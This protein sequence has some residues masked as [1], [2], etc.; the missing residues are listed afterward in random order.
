VG[1]L[2]ARG[3]GRSA[4]L[5][6]L[7]M[8]VLLAL[9]GARWAGV[10][11]P[12]VGP[13]SPDTVDTPRKPNV[14][15]IVADDLDKKLLR[16][17]PQ[18]R[19]LITE[20]GATF[21]RYYVEQSTCCTSRASI[22]SGEY[23]HNHGVRG[24]HYPAGGFFRWHDG[25]ESTALPTWLEANGYRSALLGKYLNE[26][27]YPGGYDGTD[28]QKAE[29]KRFVPPGWQSWF[30]PVDGTPYRQRDTVMNANGVVDTE[31]RTGFLDQLMGDRLLD[32]VN[33]QDDMNLRAGGRFVY[34][35]SYSP[36]SPYAAPERYD[37]E[38]QGVRYPRTP[39]F[40]EA[41]VS[42]KYGLSG[43]RGPLPAE[44]IA[45]ID[46][47][48]RERVR[49]V[50]V[51]DANVGA[52]VR[53][54]EAQGTLDDTYVVFTSDNGYNMGEHRLDIAKYNQF[55]ET[56]S[57]P[58]M[59]RGPSIE[60]GTHISE[61]AGN[62]DLAPTIADMTD[63]PVPDRVDGLSLLPLLEGGETT[64][65]REHLLLSRGLIPL[66]K[67]AL[68]AIEE[69]PET[70]VE[71]PRHARLSDFNAVVTE[72]WKLVDYINSDHEE[73]YDLR[74]DPYELTNL[75]VG[76]WQSLKLMPPWQR[77]LVRDLR[78]TLKQLLVCEAAGCRL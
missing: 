4:A 32:L 42:D 13:D 5:G 26:Y 73:L 25:R 50:Q 54:L 6:L 8:T 58:L 51:L 9:A 31:P 46:E 41:D 35:A 55:E 17:M 14:V 34:Y 65:P 11:A 56:V 69:F 3:K 72:R 40:D 44:K 49:A 57:V 33:G 59:V 61:L 38:F 52:L 29:L 53:Q 71:S 7:L 63:T 24:N 37:S 18:T 62:I 39:S 78:R 1:A 30:S 21:D 75:M 45:H 70:V 77:D 66:E 76:G 28:A 19:R 60:P 36:H 20:Q 16:W 67:Q 27:P 10:A 48:F 74:N 2:V 12:H 15:M 47:K 23:T 43:V 68:S 64:L 22:L